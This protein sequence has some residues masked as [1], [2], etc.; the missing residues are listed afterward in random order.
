M[1]GHGVT[2]PAVLALAALAAGCP[3]AGSALDA[4][5][6]DY[7]KYTPT[8]ACAECH[9]KIGV[10]HRFSTHAQAFSDPLFQAQLYDELLPKAEGDERLLREARSCLACHSPITVLQHGPG[11]PPR[12]AA[13][14]GL[15]GVTCDFCH[16]V[17]GYR[18]AAPG[19]ANYV[20]QPGE[21]KYGPFAEGTDFHH[22]YGELQTKSELCALCHSARNTH[23]V[24]VRTTFEEWQGSEY[25]KKGIQCQDCHMSAKG[26]LVDGVATFE[27]GAAAVM[28]VGTAKERS[29]LYS[30]R[31]PGAH[32]ASQ[33]SG[34]L[35]VEVRHTHEALA[36]GQRVR[37][38]V[39]VDNSRSGHKMPT[40]SPEL[41]LLWLE[42][43]VGLS[44]ETATEL[45][46]ARP[47]NPAQPLDVAQASPWDAEV[48][49][50][51]VP[52]GARLFR[53]VYVDGAG[54]Q[55]LD[56]YQAVNQVF[57]NR[58]G[59]GEVR[60]EEFDYTVP[61]QLKDGDDVHVVAA[62]KYLSAPASFYA[63]FGIPPPLPA[64]LARAQGTVGAPPR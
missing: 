24:A 11:V 37:I 15:S 32:S 40:G 17:K 13:Q 20:V 29:K 5:P 1:G 10:Q 45:L 26:F 54:A 36:P 35:E 41:R 3:R 9:K 56:S 4:A 42:V 53:A 63:R 7:S 23:G 6:P 49:G 25:A 18:G 43:R 34:A 16:T 47:A 38:E 27:T 31:F 60:L 19:D 57:D 44:D 46:R 22:A 51:E 64:T 14:P 33:M 55:T 48:L 8:A 12:E 59:A 50:P 39:V 2:A 61:P 28:T 62:L 21:T 30:H 58:L 52:A